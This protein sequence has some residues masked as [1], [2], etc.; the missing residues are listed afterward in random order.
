M[1]LSG[2]RTQNKEHD[3]LA[4]YDLSVFTDDSDKYESSDEWLSEI[5]NVWVCVHETLSWKNGTIPTRLVI[6][7][8]GTKVDFV[9]YPLAALALLDKGPLPN[10]YANGYQVLLDKD[11]CLISIPKPTFDGFKEEPPLESEFQ[12]IVREF[13]FE[14]YHVAKYL[15]RGDLWSAKFRDNGLKQEFLLRMICWH[16]QAKHN[17]DYTTHSQ[18]KRMHEWANRNTWNELHESFSHFDAED[19]WRCLDATTALFR[20]ISKETASLL[21][22]SYP[23]GVDTNISTYLKSLKE[24]QLTKIKY[25]K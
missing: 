21:N 4:D 13:W 23:V 1:I 25:R 10:D 17:W 7:E 22:F 15:A 2:S 19:S 6:F 9:F 18:G 11:E 14:V 3:D 24:K 8:K 12:R 20:R 16:E 5:G